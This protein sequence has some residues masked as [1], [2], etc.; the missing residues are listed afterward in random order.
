MHFLYK[1]IR[2]PNLPIDLQL[3]LFEHTILPI[4]LYGCEIWAYE[5]TNIIEKLQNEFLRYRCVS[6]ISY[7]CNFFISHYIPP[8]VLPL[9]LHGT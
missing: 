8:C 9:L 6:L 1:R 7:L 3:Q 4:A 2:N 5:N